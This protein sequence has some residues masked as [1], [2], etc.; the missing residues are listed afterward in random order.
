MQN[1]KLNKT[2]PFIAGAE[3]MCGRFPLLSKEGSV[4]ACALQGVVTLNF[5]F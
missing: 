1:D 4:L 5:E 3:F 2:T